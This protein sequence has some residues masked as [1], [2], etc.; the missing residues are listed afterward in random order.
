VT[1]LTPIAAIN[2]YHVCGILLASWAVLVTIIG[3]TRP[4]FPS[5]T[6]QA[7]LTGAISLTLVVATISMAIYEG[8]REEEETEDSEAAAQ[9]A[10]PSEPAPGGGSALKLAAD[11]GGQLKFD[12]TSLTADAGKVTIEMKND[13]KIPHDISIDGKGVDE[14][15]KDVTGGGTSTVT[16]TLKPGSYIFYCAVPGHR[17][18]GMEG[19]LTVR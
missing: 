18:G 17:Q 8:T 5:S 13:S 10:S 19:T 9:P 4:N 14:K 11:P 1:S 2:A 7:R 16:A 3:I 12:K 6:G 15:G